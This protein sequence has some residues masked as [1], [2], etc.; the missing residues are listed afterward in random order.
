MYF[1]NTR[2]FNNGRT[3]AG[4]NEYSLYDVVYPL[5]IIH[6]SRAARKGLQVNSIV[7]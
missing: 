6:V 1:K 2:G 5:F 4:R 3:N 7:E